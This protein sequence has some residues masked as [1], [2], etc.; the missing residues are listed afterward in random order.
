M[1]GG[2]RTFLRENAFLIAAVALP[3]LV[4]AFF[5]LATAIPRWTVPPPAYDLLFRTARPIDVAR[6]RMAVDLTVRNGRV[7]AT[8]RALPADAY[9][10]MPVLFLY[11]HRSL[12]VREIALNLPETIAPDDPPRTV[13]VDAAPGRRVLAEPQ[14]PDGYTLEPRTSHGT[15]LLGDVFG[16]QRYD[17]GVALVNHGRVIPLQ[18]P[19]PYESSQY[20]VYTVG[21]IVDEGTR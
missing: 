17:A 2:P 8:A 7:E 3:G 6:R 15:G 9:W 4:V 5:L 12:K 1:T 19:A 13:V 20:V 18:V 11:D 10:Q 16:M 14:A 21:W